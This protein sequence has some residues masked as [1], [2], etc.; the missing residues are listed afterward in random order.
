MT[1]DKDVTL[2]YK[3]YSFNGQSLAICLGS[4]YLEQGMVFNYDYTVL[5]EIK[6]LY[7]IFQQF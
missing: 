2:E 4:R 3:S 7:Q 1:G 5:F 6:D